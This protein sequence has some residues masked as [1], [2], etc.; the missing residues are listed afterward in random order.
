M[1]ETALATLERVV[2]HGDLSKLSSAERLYYYQQVCE[3]VGLNPLTRPF[4][5]LTLSGKMVLYASRDAT[6]QLRK[7]HGVSVTKIERDRHD[8]LYVAVAYGQDKD[9]RQ[10]TATG[11]VAIAGLKGDA[12]ANAIMK[13][14]TKAKRRL[15]LSLCGL[16][17]LDETEIETVPGAMRTVVD[18]QTGEILS[19]GPTAPAE[20]GVVLSPEVGA[21]RHVLLGRITAAADKKK[22]GREDRAALWAK[23]C[24]EATP[25]MADMSALS[26]LLEA[27]RN[28]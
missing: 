23:H 2:V 24:G 12:L 5:Y 11:A 8:D 3:S 26:D 19:G 22:L 25:D 16:G 9:G 10:D 13:A 6:D 14:E 27:V 4:Q 15:T 20:T 28:A 21:D 7:K 17:M 1:T 18:Q